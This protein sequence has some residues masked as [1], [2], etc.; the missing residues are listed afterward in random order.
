M[1]RFQVRLAEQ[2]GQWDRDAANA[3]HRAVEVELEVHPE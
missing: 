2:T 1:G 3:H